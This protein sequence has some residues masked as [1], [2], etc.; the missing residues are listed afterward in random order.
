VLS[1]GSGDGKTTATG[2][3][4]AAFVESGSRTVAVNADF[5]RPTLA[6]L[7]EA[8]NLAGVAPEALPDMPL[9]VSGSVTGLRVYDECLPNDDASPSE[10]ARKVVRTMPWLTSHY[11]DVVVDSAPVASAAEILEL[12]PVADNIIV[13]VRLGHT[14]IESAVRTA[15]TLRA[16]GVEDFML[17]VIGGGGRGDDAYEYGAG[18]LGSVAGRTIAGESLRKLRDRATQNRRTY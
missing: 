14:R 4:A 1:A 11:E 10:L 17:V 15:E 16:L 3:L 13:I 8:D 9:V 5:R 7:L 6:A 18:G 2:N 12:L